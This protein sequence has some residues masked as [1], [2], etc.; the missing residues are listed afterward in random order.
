MYSNLGEGKVG[1]LGPKKDKYKVC[2]LI[3]EAHTNFWVQAAED[4]QSCQALLDIKTE[5]K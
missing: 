5:R 2:S 4:S 3:D 1:L